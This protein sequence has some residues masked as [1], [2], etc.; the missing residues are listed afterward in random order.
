M[1]RQKAMVI[2]FDIEKSILMQK[3][4]RTVMPIIWMLWTQ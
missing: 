2:R 3:V 1:F 4:W